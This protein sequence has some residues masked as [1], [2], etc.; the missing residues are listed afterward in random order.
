MTSRQLTPGQVART[1][2]GID[3]DRDERASQLCVEALLTLVQNR[4][5][6]PADGRD[7]RSPKRPQYAVRSLALGTNFL[8][9][10]EEG[11]IGAQNLSPQQYGRALAAGEDLP[12]SVNLSL[13]RDFFEGLVDPSTA[14][15]QRGGWLLRPFHESLL[16]FDARKERSRPWRVRQVY[17]RGSGIT[18]AR[19]LADP[20][21]EVDDEAR[22]AG[23]RAVSAIKH[24]LQ[25]PSPLGQIAAALESP[26]PDSFREASDAEK[27]ERDAWDRGASAALAPLAERLCRHAEGV[28]CQSGASEPSKLWQLRTIFALDV[29]IHAIRTSWE[30][31]NVPRS[32]RFLLLTFGGPARRDNR[33]RRRSEQSYQDARQKLRRATVATLASEMQRI[34]QDALP[35]WEDQ[36]ENRRGVLSPVID[37]LKQTDGDTSSEEFER[38]ARLATDTADYGRAA[39]GFRVLIE[40]CGLLAGTGAYRYLTAPP[41]LL[42]ALVGALSI[43]MPMTSSEFFAALRSEWSLVVDQTAGT[44]LADRLDGADLQRSAARAEQRLSHAGL[45]I[46]LSDRTVVVG[47][48]AKRGTA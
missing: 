44:R 36:L 26:L 7:L 42:A 1:L 27:P 46:S 39:E 38:L 15:G 22:A 29:A 17:M 33:V 35:Q 13:A 43:H 19:M 25:S 2:F 4:Y 32:D 48:R 21:T 45:A 31:L 37:Q 30:T 47:E 24:A 6:A 3:P 40:S 20:P 8:A 23:R 16:W 34:A 41:D 12:G 10:V 9:E 18:L 11:R 28:M 5:E 14:Q